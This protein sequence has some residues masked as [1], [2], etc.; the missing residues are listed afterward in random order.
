M[1]EYRKELSDAHDQKSQRRS[2]FLLPRDMTTK[3]TSMFMTKP[4]KGAI[5]AITTTVEGIEV[6]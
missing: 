5:E 4:M 3:I 6:D 1:H 2:C